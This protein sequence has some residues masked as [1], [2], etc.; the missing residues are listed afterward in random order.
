MNTSKLTLLILGMLCTSIIFSQEIV[1]Q[2]SFFVTAALTVL[3]NLNLKPAPLFRNT[4]KMDV[5]W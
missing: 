3:Q 2:D 4:M 5:P 1:K